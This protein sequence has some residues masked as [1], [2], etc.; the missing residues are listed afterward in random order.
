MCSVVVTVT[1][2]GAEVGSLVNTGAC[3]GTS[4][5][6]TYR[7]TLPVQP[8]SAAPA[9]ALADPAAATASSAD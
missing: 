3:V 6:R 9:A 5:T 8:P 2:A 7:V 4:V 1:A